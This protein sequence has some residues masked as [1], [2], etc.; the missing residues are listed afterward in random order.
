MKTFF[1]KTINFAFKHFTLA[2]FL[3]GLCT[4]LIV[5]SLKYYISGS[6]HIEYTD[7]YNNFGLALLV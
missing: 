5:A 2:K 4:A 7:F 6:F 3:G 1:Y